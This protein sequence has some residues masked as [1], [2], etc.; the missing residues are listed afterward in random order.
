MNEKLDLEIKYTVDDY[1][2][3]IS[4]VQSRQFVFKYG[5]WIMP[6]IPLTVLGL[7]FLLNPN[8]IL[9]SSSE[10]LFITFVT[11]VTIC[12]LLLFVKNFDNPFLNLII[13][14][15]KDRQLYLRAKQN[16]TQ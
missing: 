6:M 12:L 15:S 4:F 8:S 11:T 1:V 16:G 5:L 3:G 7:T 2:R 13:R 14:E 10:Y 9:Q